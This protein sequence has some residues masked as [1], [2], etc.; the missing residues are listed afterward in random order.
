MIRK[1]TKKISFALLLLIA[2]SFLP[3]ALLIVADGL[4]DVIHTA[5]VAIVLGNTVESDGR[6]SARLRT[7]LDKAVELYRQGAFPYVIVSGGIGI[8]GFDE[9]DIMKRY[10]VSHGLPEDSIVAD[11]KGATTY[12]TARNAVQLMKEK[13]WQSALIITQYFHIPRTRLAVKSFGISPV[14]T[15][16]ANYF[17]LRDAYSV[18]REVIGYGEYLVRRYD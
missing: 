16:H 7:R 13:Q 2:A 18:V 1:R 3:A 10:L 6:P 17:E 9:A 12:H 15:A 8:E 4:S 5:D 11:A 14:Y